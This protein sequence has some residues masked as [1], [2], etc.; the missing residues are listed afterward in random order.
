MK[1]FQTEP[2]GE[3][4]LRLDEGGIPLHLQIF[5]LV[6]SKGYSIGFTGEELISLCRQF[7]KYAAEQDAMFEDD[8]P[9]K[10]PAGEKLS[11]GSIR[12]DGDLELFATLN[13]EEF[14][15][16]PKEF[17]EL[18]KTIASHIEDASVLCRDDA[19]DVV[20]ISD[21]D[22]ADGIEVCITTNAGEV[23]EGYLRLTESEAKWER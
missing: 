17:M 20:T 19:P 5:S 1:L 12:S 8:G 14:K 11:I 9:I 13:N 18:A 6:N 10:V 4:T 22:P 23:Y 2:H 21:E 3:H 7:S 16:P 15:I